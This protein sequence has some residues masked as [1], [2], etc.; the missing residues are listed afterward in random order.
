MN[1]AATAERRTTIYP[2]L[3]DAIAAMWIGS[4]TRARTWDLRINST[5][6]A[7]FTQRQGPPSLAKA[8]QAMPFLSQSLLHS[9]ERY[10][11]RGHR[12]IPRKRSRC[13]HVSFPAHQRADRTDIDA[14]IRYTFEPKQGCTFVLRE[15]DLTMNLRS[16][17]K[18]TSPYLLWVLSQGECEDARQTQTVRGRGGKGRPT[19]SW[20]VAMDLNN[21][22]LVF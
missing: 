11:L 20:F 15:L 1:N 21:Q 13:L 8:R 16:L 22:V 6:L 14:R 5:I 9:C 18:L 4:P 10:M 17:F 12:Q 3:V 19:T 7:A 2:T